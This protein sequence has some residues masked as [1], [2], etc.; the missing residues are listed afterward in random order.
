MPEGVL[1]V[2]NIAEKVILH[3]TVAEEEDLGT[4]VDAGELHIEMSEK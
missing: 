3:V 4:V 2:S 1:G